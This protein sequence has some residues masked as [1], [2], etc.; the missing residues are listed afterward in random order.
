M[1][2]F[3]IISLVVLGVTASAIGF[4]IYSNI[5]HEE[6]FDI[7][8]YSLQ[9]EYGDTLYSLAEEY[10]NMEYSRDLRNWISD[11]KRI[12]GIG[13]DI[14]FGDRITIPIATLKEDLK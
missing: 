3:I 14:Y 12:N 8:Y 2:K 7:E 1:K 10:C 11:V 5:K 4:R 6:K 9:I 13:D